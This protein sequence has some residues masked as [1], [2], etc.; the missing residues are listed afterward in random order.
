MKQFFSFIPISFIFLVWFLF[1]S[2]Y[3]LKGL[4]PYP[5]AYQ[6]NHSAPWNSYPK[7]W[8]PV[9]ND[10]MPDIIGQ[11]Y[12][13]KYFTIKELQEGRIPLWNPYVFSGNPHLANYQSAV[14]SPF[15]LLF[16]VLPFI[17]AWS[18]LILLQP[19]IAGI[20]MY[21]FLRKVG[22]S[23]LGTVFGSIT[24]M[25]SGFMV[26]WMAYGT[27]SL[28]VACLPFLLW[29]IEKFFDKPG[30]LIGTFL[31]AMIAVCLFS[32]HFQTS[33]Y[34]LL[35]TLLFLIWKLSQQKKRKNIM[36]ILF[37]FVIGIL[38]SM[39]QIIP[40]IEL[41]LH[42]VRSGAYISSGGIPFYYLVNLFAPDFFGNPVTRNNWHGFYAE[43][44]SFVGIIPLFFASVIFFKKKNNY[45]RF[46]LIAAGI[47]LLFILESPLLILL[48]ALKI[49]VLST[50]APARMIVLTSFSLAV[51]AAFGLDAYRAQIK[52]SSFKKIMLFFLPYGILFIVIGVFLGVAKSFFPAEM[53]SGISIAKKNTILPIMLLIITFVFLLGAKIVKKQQ[54]M[55]H[56]VFLC[57]VLLASFDSYRFAQKWMPFDEKKFMFTKISVVDAMQQHVGKTGR[58][59]GNIGEEIA[60]YY[61]IPI[62][63]G[64]DPLYIQRYGEF[65]M[66]AGIGAFVPAERSVAKLTR[67]AKNLDMVLDMLG[68]SLV[69][70]PI[71][72]TKKSWAY[73]IW[74]KKE[75][76]TV[77]YSDKKIK[78]YTNTTAILRPSLFYAYEKVSQ[79]KILQR[80]YDPTFDFRKKLL[81]EEDIIEMKNSPQGS[82]TVSVITD[83]PNELEFAIQTSQPA[84][85]FLSDNYYP[86]WY[87]YVDGKQTN[88]Y[89]SN[90]TFR[91]VFI[92]TGEHVVRFIYQPTSFY[93]GLALALVGILL[94]MSYTMTKKIIK[95][96]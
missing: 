41:Y 79:D 26:V 74:N 69:Y 29:S 9:K 15:N 61:R 12:P 39:P 86:G 48:G 68:V 49:P 7:F 16:F 3:F 33:I 11:I 24:F 72:D 87:A 19:L 73:P 60:N 94:L 43:F 36:A 95:L 52:D 1:G 91:S 70:H 89:R 66:S 83:Y 4:I 18:L 17:D 40:T 20:G 14:L 57:I 32:G 38:L 82:G 64:Y 5:S 63:E 47:S 55:V 90:Y 35:F 84:L 45:E 10:A 28:V 21:F 92:P 53:I 30:L 6:V 65:L 50:S 85:L 54:F 71:G 2:P 59:Y 34:V 31:S 81:L 25:F 27:L 46:F 56:G 22:V 23:N 96:I 77:V 44:A 93:L 78:L 13:W 42:S 8:G 62:T 80:F 37:F 76:Y 67:R 88:I 58:M 75:K 51:L